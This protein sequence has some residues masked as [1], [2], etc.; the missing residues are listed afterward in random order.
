[1]CDGLRTHHPARAEAEHVIAEL[2]GEG[3]PSLVWRVVLLL[4]VAVGRAAAA[5]PA[6]C[7]GPRR[8][9][10]AEAIGGERMRSA[11]RPRALRGCSGGTQGMLRV[12]PGL[13]EGAQGVL[14][15]THLAAAHTGVLVAGDAA[16]VGSRRPAVGFAA[17]AV[18]VNKG[19]V[20]AGTA[21][22]LAVER[23][24]AL[25]GAGE[26]GGVRWKSRVRCDSDVFDDSHR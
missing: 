11:R 18:A 10:G 26:E 9:R 20:V 12:A 8:R 19:G 6:Q 16:G 23:S 7:T 14:S 25:A 3:V 4:G 17:V 1:M 15:E 22:R 21:A 2:G 5:L 13:L 24:G